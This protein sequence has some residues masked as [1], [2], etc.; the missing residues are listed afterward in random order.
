VALCYRSGSSHLPIYSEHASCAIERRGWNFGDKKAGQPD[1]SGLGAAMRQCRKP[2]SRGTHASTLTAQ[3]LYRSAIGALVAGVVQHRN[4]L[5]GFWCWV[6]AV[7]RGD[8]AS[9]DRGHSDEHSAIHTND[10]PSR[11]HDFRYDGAQSR[12]CIAVQPPARLYE[13]TGCCSS[14]W[15]IACK[16]EE[17]DVFFGPA[18]ISTDG[19]YQAA[20]TG[21]FHRVR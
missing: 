16:R 4:L 10:T 19:R 1:R 9:I 3:A 8:F 17:D 6:C 2:L 20:Q 13:R 7:G 12:P 5:L 15:D 21:W 18:W 14:F 11:A